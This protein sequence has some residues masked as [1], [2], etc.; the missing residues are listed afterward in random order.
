MLHV[1]KQFLL[2]HCF[3]LCDACVSVF[4]M[5]RHNFKSTTN[6]IALVGSIRMITRAI[7]TDI[8]LDVYQCNVDSALNLEVM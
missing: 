5:L 3:F 1:A 6:A 8:A 2:F 4:T 7:Y